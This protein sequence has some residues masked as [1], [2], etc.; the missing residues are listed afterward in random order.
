VSVQHRAGRDG[1]TTVTL[2]PAV[3]AAVRRVLP[4]ASRERGGDPWFGAVLLDGRRVVTVDRY[5]FA[6][7]DVD[8]LLPR[9]LLP[10]APLARL[11]NA[12]PDDELELTVLPS[13]AAAGSTDGTAATL[14]GRPHAR[15]PDLDALLG[16]LRTQATIQVD[17][18][19]LRRALRPFARILVPR[20][21]PPSPVILVPDPSQLTLQGP[22]VEPATIQATCSGQDPVGVNPRYL[23]HLLAGLLGRTEETVCLQVGGWPRPLWATVHGCMHAL[24]PY[25]LVEPAEEAS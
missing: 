11:L 8:T 12:A 15:Y 2:P 7:A 24:L 19:A 20:R 4:A 14:V 17:S 18:Q 6:V 21:R 1:T 3:V 10:A 13:D 9:M 16:L 25:K 5:R 23:L 22:P